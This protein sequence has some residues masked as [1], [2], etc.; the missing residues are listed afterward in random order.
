MGTKGWLGYGKGTVQ[1]MEDEE[2]LNGER[3]N[4]GVGA[5]SA[6][7]DLNISSSAWRRR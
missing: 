7:N 6:H 2:R 3:F 5:R 1:E 4:F